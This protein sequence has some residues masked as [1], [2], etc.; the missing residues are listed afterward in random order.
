MMIGADSEGAG[1]FR[2][3]RGKGMLMAFASP[4]NPAKHLRIYIDLVNAK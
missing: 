3:A 1:F 4:V 2:A